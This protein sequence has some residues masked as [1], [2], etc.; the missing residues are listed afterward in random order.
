MP[1]PTYRINAPQVT[2]EIFED[3]VVLI[4]FDNGAYF[5][6]NKIGAEVLEELE[7]GAD[8]Q[9]IARRIADRYSGTEEEIEVQIKR[10]LEDLIT[11]NLICAIETSA[12]EAPSEI[13]AP[14]VQVPGENKP[15]FEPPILN[16]YTDMEELVMLDPIHEVDDTGWPNQKPDEADE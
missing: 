15:P 11:E 14:P 12:P 13:E 7:K 6:I 8:L 10:L 5:S 9:Q 1:F 3:E 2:Y 16:K 4:N